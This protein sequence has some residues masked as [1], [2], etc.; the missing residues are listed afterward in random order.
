MADQDR[1]TKAP[2]FNGKD[3]WTW[4]FRFQQWAVSEDLWSFYRGTAGVRPAAD[5]DEQRRWDKRNSAAFA[6]LCNA[7]EPD[8]LI[9]LIRE[10]GAT[11]TVQPAAQPGQLPV[12][13]TSQ[14]Q[15]RAAWD[16]LS[17]FYVQRQ[18]GARIIIDRELTALH[19]DSG[20]TVEQYWARGDELRQK[21]AAAGGTMD[22]H[23]WMQRVITGLGPHWEMFRVVINSQFGTLTEDALLVSLKNEESRQAA[24]STASAMSSMGLRDRGQGT[25]RGGDKEQGTK[26]TKAKV[27]GRDGAWGKLGRAPQGHCHGCHKKGHS[28]Q[29]CYKRPGDAV[30]DCV[31]KMGKGKSKRGKGGEASAADQDCRPDSEGGFGDVAMVL[32]VEEEG[33]ASMAAIQ[34][35]DGWWI[36]SCASHNFTPC[37]SDFR[38]PLQPAAVTR[39]RV[40]NGLS[41]PTQGMGQVTLRGHQGKLLT[42]TKVHYVPDLHTRLLSVSHLTAKT[43]RVL[44]EGKTCEV[45][46][47]GTVYAL[48]HKHKGQDHGLIRMDLTIVHEPGGIPRGVAPQAPALALEAQGT[49]AA[50]AAGGILGPVELAHQRMA[51]VA[52]STLKKMET[53]G[54]VSGLQLGGKPEEMPSCESCMMGK[55]PSSPSP[56]C[57]SPQSTPSLT[58]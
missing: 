43:F 8:D 31:Q 53:A 49:G 23:S 3:Y 28:W 42:L 2:R 57:P 33:E 32:A 7:L 16:R 50:E 11:E 20:E 35:R 38:G 18:L 12:I 47:A 56:M 54:A 27:L 9:R 39:V 48:G 1:R 46:R 26:Q 10:F 36:D 14:A 58:W 30:P 52:P 34:Q 41:V 13:T 51:H 15:P 25:G 22:S 19:M 4:S 5:G 21:Y 55:E 17:A 6:E 37:L 40:A 44:F 45:S 29:D 24:Q